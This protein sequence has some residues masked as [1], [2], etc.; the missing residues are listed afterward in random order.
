MTSM[1]IEVTKLSIAVAGVLAL[2]ASWW[3][4]APVARAA[5]QTVEATEDSGGN[6]VF[7]PSSVTINA[8]EMV[9]WQ[10]TG[11]APHNVLSS[12]SESFSSGAPQ[13]GGSDFSHTFNTPG[14]YAYICA[15]HSGMSGVVHV[16]GVAT[17]TP[18]AQSTGT[19]TR[20][21]T[22]T[23]TPTATATGTPATATPVGSATPEATATLATTPV[24]PPGTP[25]VSPNTGGSGGV[26]I[27][28]PDTG[29]QAAD[30]AS[31]GL[32]RLIATLGLTGGGVVAAG[33]VLRRRRA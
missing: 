27:A 26:A 16:L 18:A 9:T 10:F 31:N 28:P 8:G 14:D 15:I 23:P 7:S 3:A 29:R 12:S 21:P 30:V 2:A 25:A 24:S 22:R 33:L 32:R 13:V 1:R 5:D 19:A 17:N 11:Q 6:P 20:T 4:V